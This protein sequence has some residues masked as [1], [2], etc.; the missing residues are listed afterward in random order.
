MSEASA[1]E[2]EAA[3]SAVSRVPEDDLLVQEQGSGRLQLEYF[4]ELYPALIE[5]RGGLFVE[6]AFDQATVDDII[7]HS[8]DAEPIIA[9]QKHVNSLGLDWVGDAFD[10]VLARAIGEG[11]AFAWVHWIRDRFGREIRTG[12]DIDEISGV[13]WFRAAL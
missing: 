5:Y 4:R 10:P 8:G 7:T 1:I 13:V 3:L 6:A 2:V 11:I 12:I 9:A